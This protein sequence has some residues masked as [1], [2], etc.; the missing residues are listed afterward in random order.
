MR[1]AVAILLLFKRMTGHP[2]PELEKF[3]NN[4]RLMLQAQGKTPEQVDKEI[5]ALD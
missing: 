1:R 5:A 4:Y 3:T 2:H